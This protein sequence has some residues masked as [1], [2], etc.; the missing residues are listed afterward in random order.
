MRKSQTLKKTTVNTETKR[1]ASTSGPSALSWDSLC[2]ELGQHD[3]AAFALQGKRLEAL[4][5][6]HIEAETRPPS[7]EALSSPFLK[8][9]FDKNMFYIL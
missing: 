5:D 6:G 2:A 3:W 4:V 9:R 7:S 1:A 8:N